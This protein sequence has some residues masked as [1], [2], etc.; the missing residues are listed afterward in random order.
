VNSVAEADLSF[1][2]MPTARAREAGYSLAAAAVAAAVSAI[3]CCLFSQSR[4]RPMLVCPT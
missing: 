3:R 1:E 4:T 2:R